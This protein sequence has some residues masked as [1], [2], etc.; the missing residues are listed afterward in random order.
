MLGLGNFHQSRRLLLGGEFGFSGGVEAGRGDYLDE[1]F[2][3][4]FCGGG[5][6]RAIH[7]DHAA[8]GGNRITFERLFVGFCQSG[9]CRYSA[10]IGVLDDGADRLLEFLCEVPRG[11]QVHDVVVGKFLALDLAAVRHARAGAIGIHGCFLMGI[12]AVAQVH[13]LV[14][15]QTQG[16]GESGGLRNSKF[17]SAWI[18]SSV[19]AMA[20]S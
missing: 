12:L 11:L 1:Q 8:K 10:R 4:F 18:R 19:E 14:K 17:F 7:A 20:E 9:G 6:Y 5:I 15:R 13:D 2:G 16:G 3:H